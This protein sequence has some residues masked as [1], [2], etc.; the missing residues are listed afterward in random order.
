[1]QKIWGMALDEGKR[2]K[3]KGSVRGRGGKLE[4]RENVGRK[5]TVEGRERR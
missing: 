3:I 4:T 5:G 1:M 2:E